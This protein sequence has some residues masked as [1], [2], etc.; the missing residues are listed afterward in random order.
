MIYYLVKAANS[1]EQHTVAE[2]EHVVAHLLQQ[3][4]ILWLRIFKWW[5]RIT[6]EQALGHVIECYRSFLPRAPMLVHFVPY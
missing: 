1:C 2:F 4:R 3:W 5:Q 6:R